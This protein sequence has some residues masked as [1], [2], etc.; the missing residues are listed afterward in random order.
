MLQIEGQKTFQPTLPNLMKDLSP[1][2]LNRLSVIFLLVGFIAFFPLWG[3]AAAA[4]KQDPMHS[5]EWI[6]ELS[7]VMM[8]LQFGFWLLLLAF[9]FFMAGRCFR[10][11]C[12][13]ENAKCPQPPIRY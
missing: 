7:H 1:S 8:W 12:V 4:L 9:P 13:K 2:T 3:L 11:A 6:H 5:L 10:L